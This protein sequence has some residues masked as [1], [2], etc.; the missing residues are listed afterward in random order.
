MFGGVCSVPAVV[1]R[2]ATLHVVGQPD[3][4][5]L[6]IADALQHVHESLLDVL[7][8]RQR[9]KFQPQRIR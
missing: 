9:C 4:E 2:K 1:R 7:H 6:G 8:G 5:P 3:V